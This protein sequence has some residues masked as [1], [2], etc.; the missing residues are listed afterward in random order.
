MGNN[1]NSIV[2]PSELL[3]LWSAIPMPWT[4]SG[5]LDEPMLRRNVERLAGVPCDG[6][7]S[8]DSDGEFY[9]L[10]L[11][12]FAV[13]VRIFSA[14]MSQVQCGVQ[15]GV[16]WTNTSGIIDRIK[17]C[18]DHGISTVHVCYPYWMPLNETDVMR[19]WSDLA[20]AA[21]A[22]R[23]IHYNTPRGHVRMRAEQ[24]QWLAAEFPDQFIGTKLGSQN[25]LELSEIIGST[26]QV[27]HFVTDFTIVPGYLLGGRG[28]YSFWVNT[29]PGW[30]RKLIDYCLEGS[31]SEAMAMQS[32]FIRW[33][34][35]CVEPLVQKGYLHGIIGKARGAVTGFLEDHGKTRAPYGPVPTAD[36]EALSEMF[37]LWWLEEAQEEGLLST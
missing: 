30:H 34:C 17:V 3:G 21:P 37:Q 15:V 5:S 14:S 16:T 27:S 7:Y 26:P 35:A 1:G 9:A 29:L 11:E 18:L 8:T 10:E 32:K 22:A 24:Y 33:E 19:F 28:V 6:I 31:W 13:F 36:I 4:D 20:A 23:W 25:F 2:K 12:E